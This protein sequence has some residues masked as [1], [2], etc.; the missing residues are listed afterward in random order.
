MIYQVQRGQHQLDGICVARFDDSIRFYGLTKLGDTNEGRQIITIDNLL[1]NDYE[2][3]GEVIL[4]Q[5]D[6]QYYLIDYALS[7]S[8]ENEQIEG[9]STWCFVKDDN[10]VSLLRIDIEKYP[11][12]DDSDWRW[13]K[14]HMIRPI[15]KVHVRSDN[16]QLS[17]C[18]V[19]FYSN[20][21]ANDCWYIASES[22]PTTTT[23]DT[24]IPLLP[25]TTITNN[26]EGDLLIH[27]NYNDGILANGM[28]HFSNV[29]GIACNCVPVVNGLAVLAKTFIIGE[30]VGTILYG[31]NKVGML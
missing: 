22:V 14:R 16:Q 10:K 21:T 23:N 24:L 15:A 4:N 20:Q 5:S 26:N 29:Q 31:Y 11:Y 27:V 3:Y 19:V 28:I 12:V 13:L 1:Q 18:D 2:Y 6:Q 17:Q 9:G 25:T 8:R 30:P 7:I